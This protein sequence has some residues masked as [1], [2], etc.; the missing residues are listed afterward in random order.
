MTTARPSATRRGYTYAWQKRRLAFLARNPWCKGGAD[1]HG[2]RARLTHFATEVDHIVPLS[3]GGEDAEP[4]LQ[5]L[6]K[7]AHSRKTALESAARREVERE[8][9]ASAWDAT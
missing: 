6:C 7:S 5:P 8:Y 4:N 3:L 1:L 2:G 9:P